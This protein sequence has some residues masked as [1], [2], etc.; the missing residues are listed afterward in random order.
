MFAWLNF[1]FRLA[2]SLLKSRRHLMLENAALRHQLL[3][4]SRKT[5]R[6]RFHPFDRVL[7][8]GL[9][10]VWNRWTQAI[11]LVRP[12]TVLHWRDIINFSQSF[13]HKFK[14]GGT[15]SQSFSDS[16]SQLL[17][18]TFSFVYGTTYTIE[19]R[20]SGSMAGFQFN[21]GIGGGDSIWSDTF[22]FHGEPN[23]S[24]GSATFVV[25]FTAGL[26][27]T[28]NYEPSIGGDGS[29]GAS[30]TLSLAYSDGWVQTG[31]GTTV[32]S[33]PDGGS[34]LLLLG[35]G[36]SAIALAARKAK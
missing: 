28:L 4:L 25:D 21:G 1:W 22:T 6:A 2:L 26:D 17:L 20:L 30:A 33:A 3:V 31:S 9:S 35:V 5:K 34:T 10:L 7:W 13:T 32:P 15:S 29:G 14:L 18:G 12:E 27:A 24:I 16:D 36:L 23:G 11:R 8:V 19:G